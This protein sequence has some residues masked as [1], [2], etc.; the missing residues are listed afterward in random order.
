VLNLIVADYQG[1][2]SHDK[3]GNGYMAMQN[4]PVQPHNIVKM[5]STLKS[6]MREWSSLGEKER[7]QCY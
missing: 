7:Q 4:E 3:I 1:L 6:F 5:R 2:F